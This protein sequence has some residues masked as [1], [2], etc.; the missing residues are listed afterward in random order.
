[1]AARSLEIIARHDRSLV[2]DQWEAL[3]HRL[4][5]EFIEAKERK[6]RQRKHADYVRPK[7]NRPRMVNASKF[8]M[9]QL[10]E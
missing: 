8:A 2:L 10:E 7:T 9:D 3:Y 1:M 4:A 5:S 6:L